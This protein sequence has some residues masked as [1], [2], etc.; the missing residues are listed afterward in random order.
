M[1]SEI[2][3]LDTQISFA[4]K[5]V[6]FNQLIAYEQHRLNIRIRIDKRERG[7]CFCKMALFNIDTQVG[8]PWVTILSRHSSLMATRS[9]SAVSHH[10]N[11]ESFHDDREWLVTNFLR[12]VRPVDL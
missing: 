5:A 9:Y 4:E 10:V 7:Q 3:I 11:A 2:I 6:V 8:L 1:T 12:L